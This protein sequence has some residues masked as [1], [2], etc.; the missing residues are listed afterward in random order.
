MAE[1]LSPSIEALIEGV[2]DERRRSDTRQLVQ[3]LA[4]VTGEAPRIWSKGTIGFGE[5][6]YKYKS[7]QEG[8]FFRIGF[9][10]RATNLTLYVMSG[11]RGFEDILSRLGNVR[12]T[13]ST[14]QFSSLSEIDIEVLK[15]LIIE[16]VDH[17]RHIELAHGAIPRMSDIP[18]RTAKRP[19]QGPS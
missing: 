1:I 6:H 3:L 15:E 11:L 4:D 17:L 2:P 14:V 16:C 10:P 12:S 7:G 8:E 18:P 9:A 19:E 13:K 5:Y